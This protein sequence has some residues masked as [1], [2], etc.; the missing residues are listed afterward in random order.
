MSKLDETLD[1]YLW[2]L[3]RTKEVNQENIA[4]AKQ[5]IKDLMLELIGEGEVFHDYDMDKAG[6]QEYKS[7]QYSAKDVDQFDKDLRAELRQKVKDL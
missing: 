1:W 7:K 6:W 2:T 5:A 3:N 4:E